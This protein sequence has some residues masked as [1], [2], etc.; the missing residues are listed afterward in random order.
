M[1]AGP[2]LI[3]ST[4]SQ[5]ATLTR[6]D[7]NDISADLSRREATVGEMRAGGGK[8][9]VR[10][11]AKGVIDLATLLV[12]PN[13]IQLHLQLNAAQ[14]GADFILSGQS[15]AHERCAD[16]FQTHTTGL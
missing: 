10:R 2:S 6:L 15:S 14:V 8:L 7:V 4:Y 9:A 3:S 5:K 13:K 1:M 16:A 12:S 11:N